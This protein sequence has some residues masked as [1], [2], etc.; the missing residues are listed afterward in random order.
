[1]V[2]LRVILLSLQFSNAFIGDLNEGRQMDA[3]YNDLW[4]DF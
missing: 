3:V 2:F 4:K 1:M